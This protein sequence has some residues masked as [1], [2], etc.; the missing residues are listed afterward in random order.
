MQRRFEQNKIYT[1]VGTILISV[2][3]YQRLPLYTEQVLKKYTSRGLGVVD[4]PPHVFNIA[5]DAF[6]GVTSF[7][8]GQSIIISGESGAGKTEATKQCLQYLAAIAGSTS[9]VE[10]KVLRANPILEA[11]GNAK[12]LRNDNSSRFGK[13]LE[14]YLD[15]K[16]R[17]S[18]SATENYLLEKIR[19]VQPS[20]KERNFHIFY[21]LV[22]AASSKLRQKLKLKEDAGKY[23]Y[24]KSCTDVPSIDDT[25]DYKEVI[26]AFRELGISDSERE[27][28]F[29]ICAAIL[30]LGNC[31][32]TDGKNHS[33]G[34]QV[35]EKAVLRDAAELL[36]V[37][38]DKLLERLTT[39]EIRVRGQSAA[40]AVMGAEEASDTRHA[41]CKFVY[42]RMFDWIV[43]RINKSM[44]GGGGGRSI[45]ILDIFGFEIFEKNSFEQ[46][47]INFTNERL[48]QHFNR[49]TF[50]LEQNI[51]CSEG[52]DF[53]EI[54]YIDNQPMVDLITK[55]PH[56]VLPLL[57]EE[58]RIP[59]GSDETFLA[60]LET[61]QCK[62]PVFK[63][64]MKKRAH[65]AIK[66]YAGKVLYHCKGF[67]E[68]N[69]DT[70]TEDL[71]E[72][73]QT[74]N[75]PLLQELYPSDMQISSK[76]RKSSLATQ[77][78]Q[79]LTRLMHSLNATQPHYIRC[80]KPNNDKAP[81]KF[82]A[83]NCHEQLLYSGVF[84][85]VAIRKQ[86]FPFRLSHEE[87]EKRYSI[88]LGKTSALSNQSS[89]KGRCKLILNEMKCDPKNT[90]IGSSRVLYR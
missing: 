80:I 58:L 81:M 42:G 14:I 17:I 40:K 82:V 88:C 10:K 7:S 83:K 72:I 26:E 63:R 64:Q 67:L 28:T 23:N 31:T 47:C 15:E 43:A 53:D 75:Q 61:K 55:K 51:Y 44:P 2:N 66:H 41:L 30:H 22:K 18:S 27:Q 35:N 77:F 4:M 60:K 25:R 49:H 90:R 69:R 20:L 21:Q 87:F 12:T 57:D 50:K 5:H 24:L 8:K 62:N 37:N 71:V 39:R 89:V 19:V 9:D 79:Q 85:A 70:L 13:Y 46:L 33:G 86:G 11:F 1:N 36:G 84:E 78:Q 48:Q 38:G 3:P 68:K 65:F 76:Q 54:D 59:K 32:F 29:R 52:I 34:C 74:S 73:L 56:G 45:G 6:Y 16:G